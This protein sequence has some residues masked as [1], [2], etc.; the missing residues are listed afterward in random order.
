MNPLRCACCEGIEVLTPEVVANR[1]GLSALR[2]RVGTHSTFLE[3]MKARLSSFVLD[4]PAGE[5]PSGR[6]TPLE[7]LRTRR[8]DDASI[9]LLDSWAC[10]ADVLTFYQERIANEGYLRTATERRSVAEL[11]N[12]IGYRLRPGVASS[13]HLAFTLDPGYKVTVP[14]GTRAQNVPAPN[15]T[16]QSFETSEDF[17]ARAEWNN[18]A[19]RVGRPQVFTDA[20]AQWVSEIYLKGTSTQLKKGDPLLLVLGSAT[21]VLRFVEEADAQSDDDRTRVILQP[22][23]PVVS[24]EMLTIAKDAIE[25]WIAAAPPDEAARTRVQELK[26]L[27]IELNRPFPAQA[28]FNLSIERL[29]SSFDELF[30]KATKDN[31]SAVAEWASSVR[32]GLDTVCEGRP[33][34]PKMDT[35]TQLIGPLAVLPA[36]PYRPIPNVKRLF[37]RNGDG[38]VRSLTLF[39]PALTAGLY[40]AWKRLPTAP[41]PL[42]VYALRVK[43]SPFGYNAALQPKYKGTPPVPM[44]MSKWGDWKRDAEDDN[45]K[46][47]HLE[48][49]YDDVT[50]KGYVAVVNR[51]STKAI[52]VVDAT[53]VSRTAYGMSGKS[54]RL[55]LAEAWFTISGE[56]KDIKFLRESMV[57]AGSERLE[58]TDAPIY[59]EIAGDSIELKALYDGIEPGHTVIVSG[60]RTLDALPEGTGVRVSELALIASV[61]QGPGRRV[62]DDE[63][64][65]LPGDPVHTTLILSRPLTYTY[66]RETVIVYGNVVKATHGET[67]SEVIG[68]GDATKPFQSFT[69]KQFPITHVSAPTTSGEQSALTVRVNDVLWHVSEGFPELGPRDRSYVERQ[70]DEHKTLITFGDGRRGARLPTGFNNVVGTLRI[71]I[72]KPGNVAASSI[73][74]LSS[75]PLGV[76][77]VIN[78]LRATGGADREGRD[79]AR[80]SIATARLAMGRLVSVSDYEAFSTTFAGIGKATAR[81]LPVGRRFVVHVTIAGADDVPIDPTSDLYG[82][83][84]RALRTWGDPYLAVEVSM[85]DLVLPVISANVRI[86][87]DYLWV[88]VE[89]KIRAALIDELGFARRAIGRPMFESEVIA[90]MQSVPGVV[91][92]DVDSMYGLTEAKAIAMLAPQPQAVAL[93]VHTGTETTPPPA[94]TVTSAPP[95]EEVVEERVVAALP[96]RLDAES[97]AILPGQL[98]YVRADMPA[99][100]ALKEITS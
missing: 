42:Q 65:E 31:A 72:G 29:M 94:G 97:G 63:T 93:S 44:E 10:V 50:A 36:R 38:L 4:V 95:V 82:N 39:K 89:Q 90:V 22:T 87:P 64:S 54:T 25:Q 78:P 16:M 35:L 59:D 46:V 28:A 18:L 43:A 21:R 84:V 68:S 13:V 37:T 12:L 20:E 49:Q 80:A 85:R 6:F 8:A 55:T 96:P 51:A 5:T 41:Q 86:D 27:R 32:T 11:A 79:Q 17:A 48:S 56:K 88:K 53:T 70:D 75:K 81:R 23:G 9:A 73:S 92:V 74:I 19:P 69:I 52:E 34:G 61:R 2:Y 77:D 40:E 1:P 15:E 47:L 7:A 60:E 71:G 24:D 26:S 14:A 30:E 76:R 67:R 66:K 3:S 91:Y 83:L 45:T 98:A 58:T 57:Y 62:P 33:I 100:I 99:S